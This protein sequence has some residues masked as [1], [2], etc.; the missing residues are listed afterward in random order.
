MTITT[1]LLL[2][3]LFLLPFGQL[4]KIPLENVSVGLYMQDIFIVLTL[5]SWGIQR[6][7]EKKH[8][9]P[10]VPYI[11]IF[12]GVCAFSLHIALLRYELQDVLV[13]SLYLVRWIAY[14]G[15]YVV[16]FEN[17]HKKLLL[18]SLWGAG[19]ISAVFGLIQYLF[20]PNLRN[21][22]YLGWDPHEYRVF[23]TFFDS[24]FAGIIFVL[25]LILTTSYVLTHHKRT[26][27]TAFFSVSWIVT[28]CAL[29]LTYSRSSYIAFIAAAFVF[30]LMRR[31]V[32]YITLGAALLFSTI[33]LLPR[34]SATSEG[35]KL[36][37]TS[38]VTARLDNY[39]QS[40]AI[41]A[42]HPIVGIGFNMLRYE[43]HERGYVLEE[44]WEQ[45]HAAA[46]A[47]SS[48]IFVLATA[49]IFGLA[50]YGVLLGKIVKPHISTNHV[51]LED[52]AV[53]PSIVALTAHS[54]FLNSLFYPWCMVW[55]WILLGVRHFPHDLRL[56]TSPVARRY[57]NRIFPFI[58]V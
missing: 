36:E 51:S 30:S 41:I 22:M 46:G 6:I 28:Y 57:I 32:W 52:M 11:G 54:F 23:G 49:G 47:D 24:G 5:V 17:R 38:T 9:P 16:T 15:L 50:S 44:N 53:L 33:F 35:V 25:T 56:I 42:D 26:L 43:R 39:E 18:L 8:L 21:M 10:L 20:Y 7:F 31:S 34:P 48:L 14:A 40:F 27:Y 12:A 1:A 2:A 4:G 13:G 19:S 29:A 58:K 3:V 55:I 45:D 37:R